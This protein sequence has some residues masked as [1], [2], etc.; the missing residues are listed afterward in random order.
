M[1]LFPGG[2]THA[3]LCRDDPGKFGSQCF[4]LDIIEQH[5]A[6]IAHVKSDFTFRI[7]TRIIALQA[8]RSVQIDADITALNEHFDRIFRIR[9]QVVS[10]ELHFLQYGPR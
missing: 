9:L 6:D 5:M 7:M 8:K 1:P 10:R 4:E 2:E 3:A